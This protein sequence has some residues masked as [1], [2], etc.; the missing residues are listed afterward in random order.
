LQVQVREALTGERLASFLPIV[1]ELSEEYDAHAI[2][3]AA[4]QL[5]YDQTRP[6][7]LQGEDAPE[8]DSSPKPKLR[9]GEGGR[10]GSSRRDRDYGD[11]DRGS[12]R[13]WS[14]DSERGGSGKPKLR[15]GSPT[16]TN[17]RR[18]SSSSVTPVK[19]YGSTS[20]AQE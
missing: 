16:N 20:T 12:R 5:A 13:S 6:A 17:T 1:R 2:A 3:A 19:K 14:S 15:G 10:G 11:R 4:L 18:E 7:W 8:E 9:G